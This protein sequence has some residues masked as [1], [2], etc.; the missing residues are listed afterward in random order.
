MSYQKYNKADFKSFKAATRRIIRDLYGANGKHTAML[1]EKLESCN[2][3]QEIDRL[4]IWARTN[5][6]T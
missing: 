2:T 3:E 1:L 5:L 6:L 4:L